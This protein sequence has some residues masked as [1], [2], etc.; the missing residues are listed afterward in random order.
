MER[1]LP[2]PEGIK[3]NQGTT[4][5]CVGFACAMAQMVKLYGQT[6]K[7]IP[8]SPFS[9]YG[10]YR[11]TTSGLGLHYGLDA[12]RD[13]GALPAYEWDEHCENPDC[14]DRLKLYRK[15]HP[16]ADRS[17]ARFKLRQ[18]RRARDFADICGEIDAGNPVVMALDIDGSFGRR[19]DGR[20]PRHL[21]CKKGSHAIC[22]I[23][24]TDDGWLI[25]RNSYGEAYNGGIVYLPKGR[26]FEVAYA[27]CDVGT[28]ITKKAKRVELTAGSRALLVDGEAVGTDTAAYIKNGR[29][30]IPAR[31]VAEALGAAVEWDAATGTAT[32]RS[33]ESVLALRA[34]DKT[35]R[36]NGKTVRMDT[37]PE[38]QNN[39][40]CLPVRYI[41]ENLNCKVEWDGEKSR[42]VLLAK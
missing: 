8:L 18:Y 6:N 27:L 42:A 24:Y 32:L 34:G 9:I 13:F 26:A 37:A 12:L 5:A 19:T 40:M 7:W 41:A 4:G 20:E 39:R 23:G 28:A 10:C 1:I 36:V 14:A 22:I 31:A 25:A 15:K 33:E 11:G 21:N 38:I 2:M 17:A 30:L 3:W 29:M 16:D 35:L